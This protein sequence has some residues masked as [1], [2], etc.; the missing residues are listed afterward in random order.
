[1]LRDGARLAREPLAPSAREREVIRL[2][3]A[4]RSNDEIAGQ[5]KISRKTVEFHLTNIYRRYDLSGR[6]ALAVQA[7]IGNWVDHP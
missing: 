3:V 1:V 2:L 5:L 4:G 7:L 6:V